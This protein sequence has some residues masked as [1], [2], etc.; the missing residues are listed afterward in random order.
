VTQEELETVN[1]RENIDNRM[2]LAL[3]QLRKSRSSWI[4]LSNG[5]VHKVSRVLSSVL[6]TLRALLLSLSA[7]DTIVGMSIGLALFGLLHWA[8]RS[9]MEPLPL[10]DPHLPKPP[11]GFAVSITGCGPDPITEGAAVLQHSIHRASVHGHLGGTYDYRLYAIFHPDAAD[12]ATPLAALGYTLLERDTPVAVAEI[13]GAFL[14]EKI[15]TNGCCGEKELIKLHAYTLTDHPVVVHLDLDV[16]VLQPLDVLFDFLLYRRRPRDKAGKEQ[17]RE[18]YQSV[19]MWPERPIPDRVNA[20]YTLD[21]NMV[22]P[23]VVHKP[24]QGGFL[25]LRP[26]LKVYEEFVQI[27]RQGDY[28]SGSGWGGKVGPF[29][30]SMTFQGIIPYYY[31]IRHPKQSIELNRCYFNT[32]ADNPRT[33]KTVQDVV[34]GACRTGQDDCLDCRTVPVAQ[35]VTAHFTLCQKPWSCLA[36]S[37]GQIQHRLCRQLTH[38]WYRV[39]SELEQSWQRGKG[40]GDGDYDRGQFYGFCIKSGAAGY[41]PIGK[42]YGKPVVEGEEAQAIG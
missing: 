35:V 31:N 36:H 6:T 13:Q 1:R 38:E 17:E 40:L 20:L 22:Q 25:I 39:R 7:W 19:F 15:T 42:P 16:L 24:V 21:Y 29:Y 23:H 3:P 33:E 14:R 30:G 8:A 10:Y 12:C 4:S 34:H 37:S 41:I 9:G 26:D 2:A 11:I 27:I 32:M 18:Q 5:N 28:R